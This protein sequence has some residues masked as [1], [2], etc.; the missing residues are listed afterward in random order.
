MNVQHNE[1]KWFAGVVES[2]DDPLK[3]GRVKVRVFGEHP[4]VNVPGDIQGLTTEQLPWMQPVQDITSAAISGVG[5]SP[6]GILPGSHVFGVW[7]DKFKTSGMV[8]GTVAGIYS[9]MPNFNEG[10]ADPSGQYPRYVGNDV[11]V[12]AGGGQAG[13]DT[14]TVEQRSTNQGIAVNPDEGPADDI[15]VDNNPDNF[16][17]QKML[18]F[19]EGYKRKVYWDTEGY[20]TIGV[21]HLIIHKRTQNMAEIN[22]LLSQQVGREVTNGIITAEEVTALFD[23]DTNQQ[24]VDMRKYPNIMAAYNAADDNTPRKWALINMSFNLGAAGLAKFTT[25]LGLMAQKKWAEASVQ[26]KDSKWF[27]QVKGR[28]PRICN[29]IRFGNLEAYGVKA[30][31]PDARS[32]SAAIAQAIGND[33]EDPWTPEDS[34]IMFKEP[35]SS[36]DAQYPYNKVM[37]SESGHIIEI[38][39]TPSNERMHWRHTSGTYEEWRP[40]GSS[41]R[42]SV[43]DSYDIVSGDR[44]VL[45]EANENHVIGASLKEYV[46]GDLTIQTDGQHVMIVRGASVVRVEGNST[47][48]VDGDSTVNVKGN[49]NIKVEGNCDQVVQGDYSLK[50]AGNY[51]VSVEGMRVDTVQGSWDRTTTGGVQDI[52]SSTFFID[53]SRIDFG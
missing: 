27:R 2:R 8:L 5:Q 1:M 37:E 35:I 41:S 12:L 50:V 43:S 24:L 26:L 48:I 25:S 47:V 11:N 3:A 42:K 4:F 7:L 21:G 14:L 10:F 13:K 18:I 34:R 23:K 38:D 46:M 16:T 30:P 6:T 15:P 20:P 49:A 52:S 31:R 45:S 22:K 51:S 32:L 40:D 9:K 29:T 33:P 17:L 39:D 53:G 36:Y 28:G 44:N 19:D